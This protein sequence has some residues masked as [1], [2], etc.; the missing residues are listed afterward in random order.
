MKVEKAKRIALLGMLFALS[1]VFS[2]IEGMLQPFFMLPPGVKL[3]LANVVVM[4]ALLFL[5]RRDAAAL[6][7]LK[8]LFVLLTRGA[9]SA[10]LSIAGG[11]L[12]LAVMILLTLQKNRYTLLII[13]VSGAI[14]HNIGQLL[15]ICF[16]MTQSMYT[17]YYTPV[18]ILS[19]LIMGIL[20]SLVLK[21]LIPP[22]EKLHIIATK[23]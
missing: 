8:S 15:V 16:F 21:M 2:I 13:S 11:A 14:A 6:V 12:S 4:A 18:L 17:L 3:G 9:S 22:L 19:G 5:R 7:V 20:T 23:K 10:M 1:A